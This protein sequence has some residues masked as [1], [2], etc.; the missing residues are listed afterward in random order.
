ML[1]EWHAEVEEVYDQMVAWRRH[2]HENPELPFQ[3]VQTARM[4]G[5]ILAGYGIKVQRNIGGHGVVGILKGGKTGPTIA[6]RADMD[7][8]PIQQ[9]N[10]VPYKSQVP[11]VMHACGHDAHTATLLGVAKILSKYEDQLHGTVKFIF[12]PAEE[13]FPGGAIQMLKEGVLEGVDA[14]FGNHVLSSVPLGNFTV[15]KGS[16]TASSDYVKIRIIGKGGHSSAPHTSVNPIVIGAQI[17]TQ[18]HLLMSQKLDP[19]QPVVAAITVF[20]SGGTINVIPEEAAIEGTVRTFNQ[21]QQENVQTLLT[22]I[23]NNVTVTYG[24]TYEM[25]YTRG[26]PQLVNTEKETKVVRDLLDNIN[27][28]NV[29]E[30]PPI[31]A[32]E[33]F[34]YYLQQVPGVYFYTG[35]AT[36]APTTQF[37]HHHPKFN[38][39]EHAMKNSAKGFLSIVHYYLVPDDA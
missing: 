6:L 23:L 37:P 22:H 9:K 30:M 31:M 3:E 4:V 1:N 12:Q 5:D 32:S 28:L 20:N 11:N 17:I 26:Y 7:A 36:D 16:A 10:D 14:I 39:D 2:L 29:V 19:V 8:L 21:E 25:E 24:A 18:I 13:Q 27:H 15:P 34:A 33:D 38:I 35:S